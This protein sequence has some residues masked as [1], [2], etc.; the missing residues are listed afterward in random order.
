MTDVDPFDIFNRALLKKGN[1]DEE[2]IIIKH[3]DEDE[4]NNET[5][6]IHRKE[7]EHS[8]I[9]DD[10]DNKICQDCFECIVNISKHQEWIDYSKSGQR[11]QERNTTDKNIYKDVENMK[12][13]YDIV[14]YANDM[15]SFITNGK[16][17]RADNRKAIILIC[18]FDS[19]KLH[20]DPRILASLQKDFNLS[21]KKVCKGMKIVGLRRGQY[22]NATPI[23]ITVPILIT[24]IMSLFNANASSICDALKIYSLIENKS[25]IINRCRPQSVASAVIYYYIKKSGRVID[26]DTFTTKVNL[27]EATILKIIKEMNKIIE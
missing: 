12:Y 25:V 14:C 3:T 22:K 8:N 4:D 23:Y 26:I 7:C 6:E 24:E 20:N 2:S 19:F 17:H 16:T 27:T 15:F 13:P 10:G 11:L 9:V 21:D 5:Q 18:M 1:A